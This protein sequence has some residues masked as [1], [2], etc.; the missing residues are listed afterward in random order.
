MK[1]GSQKLKFF[2]EALYPGSKVPKG[3]K[4]CSKSQSLL[5]SEIINIY[6]IAT[7]Q[8]LMAT[9]MLLLTPWALCLRSVCRGLWDENLNP[10]AH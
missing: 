5:V 7:H 2:S 10:S 6:K 3:S 1:A 4:I 9:Q 8:P